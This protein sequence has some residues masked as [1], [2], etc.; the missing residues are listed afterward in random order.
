MPLRVDEARVHAAEI[1]GLDA[2]TLARLGQEVR[3][4]DVRDL[5]EFVEQLAL[6]EEFEA[7]SVDS[8]TKG[9]QAAKAGQI[10][11]VM[12]T[13]SKGLGGFGAYLAAS[14]TVVEF[15]VNSARS[16]SSSS[17]TRWFTYSLPLSA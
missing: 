10:D 9:V 7:I 2:E 13:F 1:G 6:H 12:G 15:L 14:R 3:E 11:L 8:G 16:F 17:A 4:K 5:D